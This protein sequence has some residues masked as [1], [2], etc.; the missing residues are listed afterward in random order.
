MLRPLHRALP[1]GFKR[2]FAA[3]MDH[4]QKAK[5]PQAAS[6]GGSRSPLDFGRRVR[7]GMMVAP[8]RHAH[9]RIHRPRSVSAPSWSRL[10]VC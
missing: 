5:S 9:D 2:Q 4:C 7:S 3:T 6:A 1:N 10:R 8:T